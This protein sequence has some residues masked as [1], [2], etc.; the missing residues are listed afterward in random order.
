MI[1]HR[2]QPF[3]DIPRLPGERKLD[4]APH[5]RSESLFSIDGVPEALDLV[6]YTQGL[7]SKQRRPVVDRLLNQSVRAGTDL[8]ELENGLMAVHDYHQDPERQRH[9]GYMANVVANRALLD[10]AERSHGG[11]P[12]IKQ[13]VNMA[14]YSRFD[15]KTRERINSY[16]RSDYRGGSL[17]KNREMTAAV[18]VLVRNDD[19]EDPAIVETGRKLFY[20]FID[21]EDPTRMIQ[22]FTRLA[23]AI[24][25]TKKQSTSFHATTEVSN[26][27]ISVAGVEVGFILPAT[28]QT[29]QMLERIKKGFKG[30]D[31]Q[32]MN[33]KIDNI[34][35]VIGFRMQLNAYL[36]RYADVNG[37]SSVEDGLNEREVNMK[38]LSD[39]IMAQ[40]VELRQYGIKPAFTNNDTI[41]K[42]PGESW[43]T[44]D[45]KQYLHA[46]DK[47]LRSCIPHV[48]GFV[49]ASTPRPQDLSAKYQ[50]IDYGDGI[51]TYGLNFD[52]NT[53]LNL[54]M[55]AD[56]DL[57]IATLHSVRSIKP[58]FER[59][60]K[61][62]LYEYLRL[63]LV[64]TLFDLVVPTD[65]IKDAD[66]NA[67]PTESTWEWKRKPSSSIEDI[68][69]PRL[70][71]LN[72]H[73]DDILNRLRSE[74]DENMLKLREHGVVGHPRLLPPGYQP[75]P[76]A[77]ALAARDGVTLKPGQTYVRS[78]KR[79][80]ADNGVILSH[81]VV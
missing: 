32:W 67:A 37:G 28:K 34:G 76:E 39:E 64:K 59:A 3:L 78:H 5:T 60:G 19:A 2:E 50:D 69:L 41:T 8:S 16:D 11:Q 12:E 62:G 44:T 80:S 57:G 81:R 54:G 15:T 51:Q 45:P 25:A 52:F 27:I 55:F 74:E 70:R 36:Q 22:D 23:Y 72:E 61:A 9:A 30:V 18:A 33:P 48:A 66:G 21:T 73:G 53:S 56:G 17:K 14:P 40:L 71:Y 79:G 46:G 77:A 24:D 35:N 65:V 42:K 75:T 4:G 43:V 26:Q 6:H 1:H 58:Y 63:N 20:T 31:S 47:T 29:L 13:P 10:V 68:M 38:E 7:N 49:L